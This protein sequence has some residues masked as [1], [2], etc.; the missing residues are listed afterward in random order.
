MGTIAIIKADRPHPDSPPIFMRCFIMYEAKKRV[1]LAGCRPFIGLDGCH[2]K[3]P[4]GGQLL[5]APAIDGDNQMLPL[6]IAVVEAKC[7]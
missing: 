4:Y 7:K 6:A 5:S 2:L 1:F 3:G